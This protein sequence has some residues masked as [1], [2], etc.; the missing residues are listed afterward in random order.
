MTIQGMDGMPS[1]LLVDDL[2]DQRAIYRAIL[3]HRG[4]QVSEAADGEEAFRRA[5]ADRPDLILMDIGLPW[6]D[7]WEVTRR[8]KA[9][10]RTAGIPVVAISAQVGS[11]GESIAESVGC[12]RFIAK[13]LE[14]R[15]VADVVEEM[16][17]SPLP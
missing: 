11:E 8:L 13:S 12:A 16:I 1:V 7:G 4:F 10:P 9:T 5:E 15:E 6:I 14:P 2:A 17:G 3:E